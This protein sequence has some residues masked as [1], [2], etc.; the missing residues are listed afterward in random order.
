MANFS[1][2]ASK[3]CR[4]PLRGQLPSSPPPQSFAMHQA[5]IRVAKIK[6][7]G[8]ARGKTA[9]NYRLMDTPNA[10][11]A[12]TATL[13]QEYVN[14]DRADYWS[15][16]EQRIAEVV[17]RKVRD[18]QVRAMEVVLT[19]SPDW[20]KR[21]QDGQADDM[22][23]SKWVTDNLHFLKEK[24]GEKNVVSFT[25][26][27]DEKTPHVHA[28]VI[29]ITDK[30]CLSADTLFNPK[31]LVK[32]QTEYA[33]AMGE[34]GLER[35]IEGSRRQHQDMKQVYGH[36]QATAAEVAPLVQPV[37]VQAF[38]LPDVPFMNHDRWRAEQEAAINAEIARQVG[39]ANQRLEKAGNVAVA[40]AGS[41][42]QAETL[43]R[44][45]A[46]S[47]GLK[48]GHYVDLEARTGQVK[49]LTERSEQLAVQLAQGGGLA[50]E[51]L[52]T[53][54]QQQREKARQELVGILEGVLLNPVSGP[55]AFRAELESV[56]YM[57]GKDAQGKGVLIDEQTGASF[58]LSELKPN[59]LDLRPQ[60]EKAI[61]RTTVAAYLESEAGKRDVEQAERQ[62]RG[63]QPH[64]G[65]AVLEMEAKDLETI[66]K[67]FLDVR[68]GVQPGQ[69][70]ADGRVQV[71]IVYQH[72]QPT[73]RDINQLLNQ[74]QKWTGVTVQEDR[75]DRE[76]RQVGAERRGQELKAEK[77]Q[78]KSQDR[79]SG[80][81]G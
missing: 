45:L 16:A 14:T 67:H 66:K 30:N 19:A 22:R 32:L 80:I 37:A 40:H 6:T 50:V 76:Q 15:L 47:Q 39:E 34:H 51:A 26:H 53:Y 7:A 43:A 58:H 28:V 8:A 46:I 1:G 68:A 36:Q 33:A 4:V 41:S 5:I 65:R 79:S 27:Q 59:G 70:Q 48:Q 24:F 60:L 77:N 78:D 57:T 12:R 9:H 49:T 54:G 72:T 71:E 42:E 52:T 75:H 55:D 38:R 13:N 73:I 17:T 29:P 3:I 11:P 23:A 44:Q 69:V 63:Q 25:L 18:D 64:E 10:D 62:V 2:Y 61:E 74:A 35:G 21:G 81:G 56:G 20:F 31:T